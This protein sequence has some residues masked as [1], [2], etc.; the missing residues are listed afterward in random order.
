MILI[1][2]AMDILKIK[3]TAMTAMLPCAPERPRSAETALIIIATVPQMRDAPEP[4]IGIMM[5]I[6]IP[7]GHRFSQSIARHPI[8][9]LLQN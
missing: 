4:G 3:E 1:M 7:M 5:G 9:T 6:G 8:I 2:M